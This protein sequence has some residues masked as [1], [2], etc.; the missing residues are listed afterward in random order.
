[1]WHLPPC[2]HSVVENLLSVFTAPSLQSHFEILVGWAM[3]SGTRTEYRVFQT[4]WADTTVSGAQRHPF[5]RFYNFFNRAKWQVVDLAHAVCVDVVAK[6]NPTGKLYLIVDDTLLHKRGVKV[7]GLGWFRDAV[8]S[9]AKRVATA[10]GNNWVVIGLAIPVPMSPQHIICLPILARLHLPGK[11]SPSCPKLVASML[12]EIL[13]W[14][15]DR[16]LVLLGDGAYSCNEVLNRLDPRVTYIGR[17]RADARLYDPV[18]PKQKKGKGGRRAQKGP[19]FLSPR[20]AVRRADRNTSGKGPWV[21]QTVT[22]TAYGVTRSLQVL[23]YEAVWPKV[24]GLKRMLVVVVRD[25]DGK[26]DDTHLCCTEPRADLAWIIEVFSHRWAI[27]VAFR[28][29]KQVLGIEGPHHWAR[30]S[31]EKLA[32]WVWLMQSMISLWYLTEGHTLPEAAQAR[33]QMSPWDSEWSLRHMVRVL[34]S[35]IMNQTINEHSATPAGQH[36]L[37]A[38]LK[39]CIHI[40]A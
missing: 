1:M 9:T 13:A 27:E 30:E 18:P 24:L 34:R 38:F 29:S 25:P 17:M 40:A 22:V 36:K 32:P 28:A 3:C 14:Y 4:I 11:D 35:K 10:S 15:P 23:S 33:E 20:Q 6:L 12:R 26:I 2:W 21:W 8:A 39:N 5:D 31:I 19:R 16:E 7:W 37:I